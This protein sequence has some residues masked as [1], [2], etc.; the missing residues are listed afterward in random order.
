MF[1]SQARGWGTEL[2]FCSILSSSVLFLYKIK[3]TIKPPFLF[4]TFR[5]QLQNYICS[6]YVYNTKQNTKNIKTKHREIRITLIPLL[7]LI[8]FLVTV[9]CLD[10]LLFFFPLDR[11]AHT[12]MVLISLLQWWHQEC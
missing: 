10:F 8:L 12:L 4:P 7:S 2:Y 6:L 3:A 5:A 1:L 11:F 9:W